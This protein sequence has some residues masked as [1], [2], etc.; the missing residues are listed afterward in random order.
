[1]TRSIGEIG[2]VIAEVEAITKKVADAAQAQSAA[3]SGIARFT[4]GR[5][6][7]RPSRAMSRS[8]I[9]VGRS[10]SRRAAASMAGVSAAIA[11]DFAKAGFALLHE[12]GR[13]G[14]IGLREEIGPLSRAMYYV[15]THQR[16]LP[17][18]ALFVLGNLLFSPVAYHIRFL[19]LRKSG[20]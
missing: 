17:F 5:S 10:V 19:V 14:M 6:S 8:L 12:E 3:T 7:C 16:F 11:A 13:G 1:M 20:G 18:R 4:S 9:N 15:E 2:T